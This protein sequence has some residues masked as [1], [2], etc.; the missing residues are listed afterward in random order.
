[1][2]KE[3]FLSALAAELSGLSAAEREERLAFY[4]EAIA[5]RMEDGM[6]EDE[7]VDAMG[8]VEEVLA[9]I[10]SET[11]LLRLAKE[12]IK[13]KRGLK[14][15]EITLLIA[16]S[17]MW[18]TLLLSILATLLSVYLCLWS[19]IAS[20]WA[21][22]ASLALCAPVGLVAGCVYAFTGEG[23]S[24]LFLV[25][26]A[27]VCGGLAVFAFF[28]CRAATMGLVWLTKKCALSTKRALVR[29]NGDA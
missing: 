19:A 26:C 22:F 16:G 23:L 11:P 17:P 2:R 18:A 5:D 12:K 29:R 27:L 4:G 10:L 15:W 28:G 14:G 20:L 21:A 7:A 25:A 8:S 1:M 6:T 9:Q 3:E 13:P 24:G